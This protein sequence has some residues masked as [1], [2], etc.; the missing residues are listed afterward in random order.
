[1]SEV[2]QTARYDRGS[3]LFSRSGAALADLRGD[4]GAGRHVLHLR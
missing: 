4:A 1:M 3:A 2:T